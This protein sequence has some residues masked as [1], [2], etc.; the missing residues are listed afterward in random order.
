MVEVGNVYYP[1]PQVRE[2]RVWNENN[3][4]IALLIGFMIILA[5]MMV[6]LLVNFTTLQMSLIA[7]IG[8][9]IY[10][11]FLFFLLEPS[12][13]REIR[14]TEIR[15]FEKPIIKEVIKEVEKPVEVIVEKP[16][17]RE[18]Y[19]EKPVYR[20]RVRTV[21]VE[22]SKK[23]L[24]IPK[25][26]FVGSTQTRTYHLK[27]CRLGRLIKNK[28]KLSDNSPDFFKKKKFKTCKICMKRKK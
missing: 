28:Y 19:L 15:T 20:D 2:Y 23:K 9:L 3:V 5:E 8:L 22:K 6:F 21:Y 10:A 24:N 25:Y 27:T 7:L 12:R 17:M 16:V 14:Q 18:V 1:K 13:V 26:K 4:F 11:L